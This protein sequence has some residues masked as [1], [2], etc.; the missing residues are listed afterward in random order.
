MIRLEPLLQQGGHRD[1]GL[2]PPLRAEQLGHRGPPH[3]GILGSLPVA[4][5]CER[6]DL[7][8]SADR[9]YAQCDADLPHPWLAAT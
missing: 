5:H 9:V 7:A 2:R 3:P 4:V 1:A 8:A 6:P